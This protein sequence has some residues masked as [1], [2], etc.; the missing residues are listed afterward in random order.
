MANSKKTIS[1]R[2]DIVMF[3]VP[4]QDGAVVSNTSWQ[5]F[6]TR[7]RNQD[8]VSKPPADFFSYQILDRDETSENIRNCRLNRVFR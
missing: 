2:N 7:I 6:L 3:G 8:Q 5:L 4:Q 1:Q